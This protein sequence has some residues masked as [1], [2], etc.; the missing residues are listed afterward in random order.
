MM[1]ELK[2]HQRRSLSLIA[3]YPPAIMPRGGKGQ[4]GM[5]VWFVPCKKQVQVEGDDKGGDEDFGLKWGRGERQ[6]G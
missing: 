3:T 5:V 1:A 4:G 6:R 2:R